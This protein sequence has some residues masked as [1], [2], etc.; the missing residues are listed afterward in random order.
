MSI[1]LD[2]ILE[3]S[4]HQVLMQT[5]VTYD[6][7]KDMLTRTKGNVV[8]AITAIFLESNSTQTKPTKTTK[9]T[10]EQE[11]WNERRQICTEMELEMNKYMTRNSFTSLQDN[12]MVR[13]VL[14]KPSTS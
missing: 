6:V 13:T 3:E 14:K 1:K 9:M 4:I 2:Y 7:A 12:K 10:K 8:D 11:E 5:D